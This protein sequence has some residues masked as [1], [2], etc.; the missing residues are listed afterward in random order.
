VEGASKQLLLYINSQ[1]M[2]PEKVREFFDKGFKV[3]DICKA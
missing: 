2:K 1:R 3:F